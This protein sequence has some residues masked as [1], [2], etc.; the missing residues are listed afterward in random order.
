MSNNPKNQTFT[1]DFVH[2][3]TDT[4]QLT[5]NHRYFSFLYSEFYLINQVRKYC[6]LHCSSPTL[7]FDSNTLQ[8]TC[9]GWLSLLFSF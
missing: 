8:Q 3:A 1:H 7:F 2:F 6:I 4:H 9:L 5:S